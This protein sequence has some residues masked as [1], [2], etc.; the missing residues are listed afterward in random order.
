V[1]ERSKTIRVVDDDHCCLPRLSATGLS[2]SPATRA[3][4]IP[5]VG[6]ARAAHDE[7]A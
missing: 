5:A 3:E 7:V 1:A 6:R 2:G 4:G